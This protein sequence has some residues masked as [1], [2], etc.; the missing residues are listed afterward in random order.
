MK[1]RSIT[2]IG[3]AVFGRHHTPI[4]RPLVVSAAALAV[5]LTPC[6]AAYN[7]AI[8]DVPVHSYNSFDMGPGMS[9]TDIID[10]FALS[11]TVNPKSA[12]GIDLVMELAP[13][14]GPGFSYNFDATANNQF[15]IE[16]N[17]IGY[18]GGSYVTMPTPAIVF[19]GWSGSPLTFNSAETYSQNQTWGMG[20]SFFPTGS[21]SFESISINYGDTSASLVPPGDMV[22][23][24]TAVISGRLSYMSG[25]SDRSVMMIS[26]VPEVTSSFTLF[27]LI[28]SGM[29]LRR[30][31]KHLS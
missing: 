10:S 2:S 31:T 12:S 3:L 4:T 6:S 14:A 15:R 11:G 22:L 30:R 17:T 23:G 24:A 5:L 26:A 18:G 20:F 8:S 9:P 1:Q 27:G 16:I 19:N 25:A 28:G 29:L 7:I 13:T 21:F